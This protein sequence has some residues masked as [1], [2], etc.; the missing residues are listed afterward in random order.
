[1]EKNVVYPHIDS[2]FMEEE[3]GSRGKK[4]S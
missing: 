1:M 4:E 3:V 2:Y